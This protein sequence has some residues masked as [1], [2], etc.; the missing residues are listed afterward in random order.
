MNIKKSDKLSLR[1][2]KKKKRYR[3]QEE[4]DEKHKKRLMEKPLAEVI[5]FNIKKFYDWKSQSRLELQPYK[6]EAVNHGKC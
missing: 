2:L 3:K 1:S 5:N 4:K 6:G